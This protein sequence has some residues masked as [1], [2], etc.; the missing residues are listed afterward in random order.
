METDRKD[1]LTLE[2]ILPLSSIYNRRAEETAQGAISSSILLASAHASR[3][4][5][6]PG[7]KTCS[8]FAL[9]TTSILIGHRSLSLPGYGNHPWRGLHCSSVVFVL[10]IACTSWA[11]PRS[12]NGHTFDWIPTIQSS[13]QC[14]Q[15]TLVLFDGH[16]LC[17]SP[18]Y[19]CTRMIRLLPQCSLDLFKIR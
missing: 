8:V 3:R 5:L 7:P 1:T 14:S 11:H 13:Q 10:D 12:F 19:P 6:T 9:F 16:H 4:L 15:L 17:Y 18:A 2:S